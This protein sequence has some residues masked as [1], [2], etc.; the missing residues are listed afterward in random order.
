MNRYITFLS[1]SL[2][3]IGSCIAQVG[4]KTD[5]PIKILNVDAQGDNPSVNPQNSDKLKDDLIFRL[6]KNSE[7][8]LVIGGK[9]LS[10]EREASLELNDPNKALLLNRVALTS[11][12]DLTTVP[13]P[14]DGMII[15][16]TATSGVGEE[17]VSPGTYMN[18]NKR[19]LRLV[20]KE[21]VSG[22]QTSNI[23]NIVENVS[24]TKLSDETTGANAIKIGITGGDI[25]VP[26]AGRYL[27]VFRL[28][29]QIATNTTVRYGDYYIYLFKKKG[30]IG[31]EVLMDKTRMT[32]VKANGKFGTYSPMLTTTYLDKGDVIII[33]FGHTGPD[34]QV[35]KLISSQD[36][37]ANRTSFAY[38][39][40]K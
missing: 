27:F 16:N 19:W 30:G 1:L 29:G 13:L 3:S 37:V 2:L 22:G 8:N 23:K 6:N 21:I 33:R 25:V 24:S 36:M 26:E 40:I 15:Y 12:S 31:A 7:A 39:L 38:W 35:W 10:P 17:A 9:E 28:Y 14:S 4:I 20:D 34:T 18:V 5:N 11:A 32:V